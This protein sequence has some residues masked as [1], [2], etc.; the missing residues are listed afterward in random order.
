[1]AEYVVG[2]DLGGT[3]IMTARVDMQG[4]VQAQV[5]EPTLA[6][7]GSAAV[8]D[9]MVAS[10]ERVLDGADPADLVGVGVGAPGPLDPETGVLYSPP[11]LP[12]WDRV[13]LR[14][15]LS[16]RLTTRFGRPVRVEAENDA[17][18]AALGEFRFGVRKQ[19]PTLRHM[20]YITVSTG[21]GGGLIAD[22]RI[23][24]GAHGMAAEI[25][26]MT[27]DMH[28][29]RCNCGNIGCIE[30]IA[31][32][33]AIA[34]QGGEIVARGGGP[35]LARLAAGEP[36][37]VTTQMVEDAAHAGDPDAL[38]LIERT[39]VAL[40]VAVVN[41]LHLY[42]PEMVVIGGGVAKIGAML[43]DP[44]LRTV[45]ERAMPAFRRDAE[46]VPAALGDF[47]GVLGA[48]ALVLQ[49]RAP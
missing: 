39:G 3:K 23:F 20:V 30:A 47:V 19:H 4:E 34:R 45:E 21:I 40:G 11:N 41:V 33:P 28:G 13:P 8:I 36:E 31:A 29:P 24:E 35:L 16:A 12:G 17:N 38:A 37:A 2:I 43:F 27:V 9:R 42:N 49:H 14:D 48:A 6:A 25:G 1:M 44:L 7:E 22:G 32:G 26:H 10:V 15:I 46:I 5:R 18:A